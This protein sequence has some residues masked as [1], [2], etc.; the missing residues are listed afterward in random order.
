MPNSTL[1]LL[2]AVGFESLS[3][4]TLASSTPPQK[5]DTND[6]DEEEGSEGAAS[7]QRQQIEARCLSPGRARPGRSRQRAS[8][9]GTACRQ[10]CAAGAED[11]DED[12][13]GAEEA[14]C[15]Q[16]PY[17]DRECEILEG[18]QEKGADRSSDRIT[19]Q[20][21]RGCESEVEKEGTPGFVWASARRDGWRKWA[22]ALAMVWL[23]LVNNYETQDQSN[24]Y[25]MEHLTRTAIETLP[26]DAIVLCS[27]DLQFN[28]GASCEHVCQ[29]AGRQACMHVCHTCVHN[30]KC[31]I[32][33]IPSLFRRSPPF[34]FLWEA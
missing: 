22:M 14:I 3:R 16:P 15:D 20:G 17:A 19:V 12:C 29:L 25:A 11:C 9:D 33:A 6:D 34:T 30:P 27:G 10:D 7:T 13:G 5:T 26:A 4:L 23:Q 24:N 28:P 21:G 31:N 8:K 1:F 32:G 18:G 2:V